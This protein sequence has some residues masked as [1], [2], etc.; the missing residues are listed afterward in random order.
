MEQFASDM[1]KKQRMKV[2]LVVSR[3]LRIWFNEDGEQYAET[4]DSFQKSYAPYMQMGGK[5]CLF[6]CD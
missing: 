5:K 2:C 1:A 3:R 6:N 4:Q